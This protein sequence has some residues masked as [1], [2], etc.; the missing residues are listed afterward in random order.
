LHV[1]P[2]R[3]GTCSAVQPATPSGPQ[4]RGKHDAG[5]SLHP[6]PAVL[7]PKCAGHPPIS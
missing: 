5:T 1:T 7:R 4:L 6:V 2:S 3:N